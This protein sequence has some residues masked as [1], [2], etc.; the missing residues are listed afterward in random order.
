MSFHDGNSSPMNS[1]WSPV[2]FKIAVRLLGAGASSMTVPDFSDW[3]TF[4]HLTVLVPSPV[5]CV[6]FQVGGVLSHA[7]PTGD[8]ATTGGPCD[9]GVFQT[10]LNTWS[11]AGTGD[12]L[13]QP[14]VHVSDSL[15]SVDSASP[16]MRY[17][18]VA[19]VPKLN[20]PVVYVE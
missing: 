19:L 15:V 6:V 7:L 20:D 10:R 9:A 16:V 4:E 18:P 2:P 13:P 14:A 11:E 3:T 17:Q 1:A 12:V 5:R 8:P